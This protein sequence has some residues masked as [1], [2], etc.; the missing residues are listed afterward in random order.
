M[1]M[2]QTL[3]SVL[4]DEVYYGIFCNQLTRDGGRR[5]S[6]LH[7]QCSAAAS[8][9]RQAAGGLVGTSCFTWRANFSVNFSGALVVL[10]LCQHARAQC[11]SFVICCCR[12][13]LILVMEPTTILGALVGSYVNKVGSSEPAACSTQGSRKP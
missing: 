4:V 10:L 1:S 8:L 9:W 11:F 3:C 6:K 13:D 7:I 5:H 2:P 12:R